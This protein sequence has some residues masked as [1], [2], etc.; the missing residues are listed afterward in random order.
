VA[1]DPTFAL[2][3]DPDIGITAMVTPRGAGSLYVASVSTRE[4]VVR[5]SAAP[6]RDLSFD[7][8]VN[9]L[10]LGFENHPTILPA[11]AFPTATVPSLEA[12]SARLAAQPED[13]RGSTPL[14]R[15]TANRGA[16]ERAPD[17]QGARDLIAGIDSPDHV[18]RPIPARAVP[19]TGDGTLPKRS[20]PR[21][22]PAAGTAPSDTTARPAPDPAA[23]PPGS[24]RFVYA[25]P[26]QGT[27]EAGSV[28]SNDPSSPGT[29]RLAD[30]A[31]DPGVI[32]VVAGP[33]GSS[34]SGMA[35]IAPAGTIA[36]CRVDATEKPVALND[37]LVASASPGYAMSAGAEARQ[38]TVIG[39]ALEPLASGT[40]SIRILVMSR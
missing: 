38:G 8:V 31:G 12:A 29:L 9:G 6:D 18:G 13:V 22:S 3:T 40:G 33:A 19:Q 32:G 2:T 28:V 7:Y 15:F 4:L 30:V 39:K 36:W 27:V 35:T 17:L 21:T 5:S 37:L 25:A 11:V 10:R 26:V 14:A 1:L 20:A 34:F 23:E 24:P 16:G